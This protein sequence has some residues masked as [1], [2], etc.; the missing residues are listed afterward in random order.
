MTA[1]E[2]PLLLLECKAGD[3]RL[4]PELLHFQEKLNVPVVIQLVAEKGHNW[5]RNG[6]T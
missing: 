2:K 1:N 6:R 5:K 4:G 3:S